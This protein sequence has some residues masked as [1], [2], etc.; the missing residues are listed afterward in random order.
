MVLRVT[1][2]VLNADNAAIIARRAMKDRDMTVVKSFTPVVSEHVV[3]VGPNKRLRFKLT[4]NEFSYA[5]EKNTRNN[6]KEVMA[7]TYNSTRENVE[8]QF[9][10]F[11]SYLSA[12]K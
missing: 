10:K 4:D 6:W 3:Q 11:I 9:I 5:E 1:N 2:M 8:N 12:K 7:Y